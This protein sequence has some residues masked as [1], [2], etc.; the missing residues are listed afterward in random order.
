MKENLYTCLVTGAAG[1][2]GSHLCER[3]VEKYNVVGLDNL[4]IGMEY[5]KNLKNVKEHPNFKFY[6]YGVHY[7]RQ[8]HHIIRENKFDVIFHLAANSDISVSDPNIEQRDTLQTTI[9]LL[10]YCRLNDVKQFL[11][12]S[13]GSI[14]GEAYKKTDQPINEEFG[15]LMP[16]SHYAAAKL[17]SEAFISSYSFNYDINSWI[18]R[19][20]NI[21]GE[22][23]THGVILDFINKIKANPDELEVL[24]DGSQTKPYLYVKDLIDAMLFIWENAKKPL[25][26]YNIAGIGT[27][28]VAEIA[29]MVIAE[30]GTKTKIR[31]TGGDRGW[32]SDSPKYTPDTKKLTYLG[33]IPNMTSNEAVRNS[34]KQILKEIGY[35]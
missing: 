4:S 18:F 26:Y 24:G 6:Y 31:Y 3:L 12:A 23:A 11:F 15:A 34:I 21:I 5:L 30:M 33:W 10:E 7:L 35:A 16:I 9:E 2:I 25:N 1:F 27:T 28:S 29:R 14:Y 20:P 22:H 13:S 8:F 32:K 19:F 17:A